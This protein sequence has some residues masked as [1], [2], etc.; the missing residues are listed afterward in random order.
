MLGEGMTRFPI[1]TDPIQ[2][3]PGGSSPHAWGTL[4][5][6]IPC[7]ALSRFIPTCVARSPFLLA[8]ALYCTQAV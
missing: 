3:L 7:H 8:E 1:I 4:N 2:G 6:L 5:N